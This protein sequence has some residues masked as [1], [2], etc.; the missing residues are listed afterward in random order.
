MMELLT[1]KAKLEAD[2]KFNNDELIVLKMNNDKIISLNSQ[3]LMYLNNEI[4]NWKEKYNLL[5]KESKKKE[6]KLK[7]EISSLK[8]QL[9]NI[10]TEN[11]KDSINNDLFNTNLNNLMNYFKENLKAQNEENKNMLEKMMKAKQKTTENGN[12]LFKNYTELI[13]KHSELKID[14]NTKENQIQNLEEQISILNIYKDICN[15]SKSFQCKECELLFSYDVFRGH[16]NK[17]KGLSNEFKINQKFGNNKKQNGNEE[18]KFI[19]NPEKLKIKIIKGLLKNDELGKPFLE[20][21]LDVNYNNQNW[22]I[23]KRFNQFA[24]LYKTIKNLFKGS[25]KMPPSSN[26]F[27]DFKGNLTG[28]FHENKIQQLEKFIKDLSE[29]NAVNNSNIFKKFLEFNQNFDEE[30]EVIYNNIN[31]E[32]NINYKKDEKIEINNGGG[33]NNR[34]NIESNRSNYREVFNFDETND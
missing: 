20:Y 6:E 34:Y 4:K 27:V 19:I 23:Y 7:K 14:L 12:E 2:L 25:I 28:S 33:Y 21:I 10:Q 18:Y 13:A 5:N 3:K 15:K 29:I 30:N 26:I 32:E 22:R 31:N 11:N 24:N 1:S 17:C 9:K 8:T 16:Y